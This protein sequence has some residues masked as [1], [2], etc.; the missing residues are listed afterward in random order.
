MNIK[1]LTALLFIFSFSNNSYSKEGYLSNYWFNDSE[2]KSFQEDNLKSVDGFMKDYASSLDNLNM[3]QEKIIR[4]TN[5]S[6]SGFQTSLALGLKGKLGIFS[7][8][9]TKAV[10]IDW[11][12]RKTN[13]EAFEKI[14]RPRTNYHKTLKP[15][16]S[17]RKQQRALLIRK[18]TLLSIRPKLQEDCKKR[19]KA[20][21]ELEEL[22]ILFKTLGN[23]SLLSFNG[24]SPSKIEVRPW[25]QGEWKNR[26]WSAC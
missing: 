18:S 13:N 8:G 24:C 1:I 3:G 2:E 20:K 25:N 4:P 26:L 14:V 23:P 6:F 9:G 22:F 12:R 17:M 7:W 19:W 15:S 5:W 10:E 11:T 16:L 21:R